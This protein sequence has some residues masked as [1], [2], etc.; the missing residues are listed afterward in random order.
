MKHLARMMFLIGCV[1][2]V[3]ALAQSVAAPAQPSIPTAPTLSS[4]IS[5]LQPLLE[6]TNNDINHLRID[7][8]KGADKQQAQQMAD[9]VRRNITNAVPSLMN[10]AQ[11]GQGSF[12]STFKLYHDLNLVYEFV[13]ALAEGA[14][15][16]GKREEYESL[17]RDANSFDNVRQNLSAYLEQTAA[18]L[19]TRAR[20]G[21][22]P[23]AGSAQG[24]NGPKKIV[25]DDSPSATKKKA[26]K[27]SKGKASPAPS[28]TPSR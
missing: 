14:S 16:S 5:Q 7:K 22:G 26:R 11:A 25:I 19:E 4:V 6:T 20:S 17:A 9:S 1:S 23:N 28:P 15:S 24:Q 18:G 2:V 21:T 3:S 12:S 8:W 27:S 13:T 10:D